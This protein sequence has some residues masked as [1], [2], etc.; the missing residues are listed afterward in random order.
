MKANVPV[1]VFSLEMSKEQL[2]NRILCSESMVDSNKVRTGK[3]EED[4]WTK[5][6][7]AIGP[8]SEA[9]ILLMILQVLILR[10]LGRNVES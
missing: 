9:E 8:L 2:V 4:D 7:G 3:L 1:A 5:L 6:A 10:K